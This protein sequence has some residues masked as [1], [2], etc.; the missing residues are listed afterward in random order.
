MDLFLITLIF[1]AVFYCAGV[2]GCVK[3]HRI[4]DDEW[5]DSDRE[6]GSSSGSST[7]E[8]EWESWG[9]DEYMDC[10][11]GESIVVKKFRRRIFLESSK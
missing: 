7:D 3:I 2:L 10:D 11:D 4:K 9:S 1:F 6:S 8:E 5:S